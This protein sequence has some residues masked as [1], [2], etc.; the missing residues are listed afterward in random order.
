M[1][2]ILVAKAPVRPAG[3]REPLHVPCLV[4]ASEY[5]FPQLGA[6]IAV[7]TTASFARGE[8]SRRKAS[9]V[10]PPPWTVQAPRPDDDRQLPDELVPHR[11]LTDVILVGHVALAEPAEGDRIEQSAAVC[12]DGLDASFVI[13]AERAGRVP[14]RAPWLSSMAMAEARVGAG[15][16]PD[17][18]KLGPLFSDG[19]DFG[20]FQSAAPS[21]QLEEI[22]CPM[23]I[24]LFGL[25]AQQDELVVELPDLL[26]HVL[27]DWAE[28]DRPIQE[29]PLIPDTVVVDLDASTVSV[30]WRGNVEAARGLREIDRLLVGFAE[31]ADWRDHGFG[32]VLR[33]L[34]RGTF[35]RVW[36]RSDVVEGV[37]PPLLTREERE[38]ARHEAM[39]YPLGSQ[40]TLTLEEHARIAAELLD[41]PVD[42]HG[43]RGFSEPTIGG[44]AGRAAV[45]KRYGMDEFAWGLEERSLAERLATIPPS[46]GSIHQ[47]WASAMEAALAVRSRP[48]EEAVI[49]PDYADLRVQLERGA[50]GPA[51]EAARLSL[52]SWIRIDRKWQR[53]MEEDPLV[54]AEIDARMQRERDRLGSVE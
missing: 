20:V 39:G 19:F 45:L 37:E 32:L 2:R 6:T 43:S 22:T 51:L 46:E 1:R 36:D 23:T 26:P 30:V 24:G 10:A 3:V 4:A 16:T 42:A 31:Q 15:A 11:P 34:S 7:K 48:E 40:A 53:K 8:G 29:V 25:D 27:V 13:R 47:A 14:L 54:R 52:G 44:N 38:M 9:Y 33:E 35:F 41:A 49:A 18:M 50:P 28:P 5:G 12:I 21:M 17:P